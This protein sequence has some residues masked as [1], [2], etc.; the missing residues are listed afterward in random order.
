MPLLR[1]GRCEVMVVQRA[2]F[3]ARADWNGVRCVHSNSDCSGRLIRALVGSRRCCALCR[4][5]AVALR[6]AIAE[7][8][9]DLADFGNHVKIDISDNDFV[10][11]A[12]GLGN[13][14]P[15][16]IAEITLAIEFADAPRLL[17]SRSEE[18]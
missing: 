9:P 2:R 1:T 14:L 15:P 8:L 3:D 13:D 5:R 10:F 4:D 17:R 18:H 7:E 11:V 16:R 6:S 12:A